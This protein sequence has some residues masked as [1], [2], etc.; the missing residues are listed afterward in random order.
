M[1]KNKEPE[2][3]SMP[4]IEVKDMGGLHYLVVNGEIITDSRVKLVI[5]RK[6]E[7]L[8]EALLKKPV[9]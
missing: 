7:T 2:T 4:T 9:K 3:I 8:L 5:E 6:R 1:N